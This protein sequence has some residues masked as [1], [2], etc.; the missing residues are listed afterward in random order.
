L[1]H[2]ANNHKFDRKIKEVVELLREGWYGPKS[3]EG[4]D[5]KFKKKACRINHL[6]QKAI[7]M[8]DSKLIKYVMG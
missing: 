2:V 6:V 3:E 5:D 1:G 8:A 4:K 7:Y